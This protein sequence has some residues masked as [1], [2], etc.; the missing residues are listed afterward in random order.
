MRGE[1][2]ASDSPPAA[3]L[4]RA[5]VGAGVALAAWH[6]LQAWQG[7]AVAAGMPTE[8][9]VRLRGPAHLPAQER[10]PAQ[11]GSTL[12]STRADLF[13]LPVQA[14]RESVRAFWREAIA[15]LRQ[16]LG[17][18]PA[19]W[20]WT[21]PART[22]AG[23]LAP[24]P[25]SPAWGVQQEWLRGTSPLSAEDFD[26]RLVFWG[27]K[28]ELPGGIP[29]DPAMV[30]GGALRAERSWRPP[31]PPHPLLGRWPPQCRA[32]PQAAPADTPTLYH[33]RSP[34]AGL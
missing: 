27:D 34:A 1:L 26:A 13:A 3:L 12:C 19:A 28:G 20:G 5:V 11:V 23:L 4:R 16:Q 15:L 6:A 17:G 8:Q 32:A 10:P 7:A 31:P 33:R 21:C 29:G 30:V 22:A 2:A 25:A 14:A 18:E 24:R 9:Q